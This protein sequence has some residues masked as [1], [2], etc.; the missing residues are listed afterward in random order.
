MTKA[1]TKF[2]QNWVDYENS[3]EKYLTQNKQYKDW[4]HKKDECGNIYWINIKTLKEQKEHPGRSI[5]YANKKILKAKADQELKES[6]KPIFERRLRILE[7][8]MDIKQK[9]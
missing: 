9:I 7:T 8:I 5:F 4:V 6:F 3:L 1:E 2:E